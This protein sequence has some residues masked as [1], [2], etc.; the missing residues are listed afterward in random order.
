MRVPRAQRDAL[1]RQAVNAPIQGTAAD[2]VKK[3]MAGVTARL[4][5]GRLQARLLL[6][7]HDELLLECPAAEA[8]ATVAAVREA[9]EGA[10]RL[11]VPM[12]VDVRTGENW[13]AA[14]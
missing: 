6:Q 9:M 14:H 3:A 8:E 4:A 7:V 13:A 2:I 10:V 5:A 12:K 1:L 11:A